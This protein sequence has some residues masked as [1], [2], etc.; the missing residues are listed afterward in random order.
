MLADYEITSAH[1][2]FFALTPYTIVMRLLV[3]FAEA[4]FVHQM[5]KHLELTSQ[6]ALYQGFLYAYTIAR[7]RSRHQSCHILG[8]SSTVK[9]AHY[10]HRL[11][12]Q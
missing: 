5:L 1:A 6:S 8:T 11:I 2:Q 12:I 9:P 10:L 7:M 4:L 3:S